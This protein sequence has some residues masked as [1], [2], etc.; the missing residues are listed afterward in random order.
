MP[1]ELVKAHAA[2]DRA[3]DACYRAQPF[4]SDRQRVEFLFALHERYTA[5]L[6]PVTE[7]TRRR[8]GA[9]AAAT[10]RKGVRR[11]TTQLLGQASKPA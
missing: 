5:P 3:V 1:P 6:L 11:E 9:R 2:L 8:S 4:I 10:V 7:K